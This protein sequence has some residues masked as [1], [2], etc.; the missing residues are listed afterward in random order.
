MGLLWVLSPLPC[1]SWLQTCD[2]QPQGPKM[3]G[4]KGWVFIM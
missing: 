1:C 3:P 4:F 2:L